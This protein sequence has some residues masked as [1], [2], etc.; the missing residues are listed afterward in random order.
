M[1]R[2]KRTPNLPDRKYFEDSGRTTN[3]SSVYTVKHQMYLMEVRTDRRTKMDDG[4]LPN[5]PRNAIRNES[6]SLFPL[7]TGSVPHE[8]PRRTSLRETPGTSQVWLSTSN[9]RS[10]QTKV[11]TCPLIK[12]QERSKGGYI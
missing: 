11:L 2:P 8:P 6:R 4:D 10:G 7:S 3:S 1:K 12:Y 9:V 5:E